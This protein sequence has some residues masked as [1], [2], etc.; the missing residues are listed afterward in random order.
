MVADLFTAFDPELK[1][2]PVKGKYIDVSDPMV[3]K[4]KSCNEALVCTEV[5]E[6]KALIVV[7][8]RQHMVTVKGVE[9]SFFGMVD[10]ESI[11]LGDGDLMLHFGDNEY[12][13]LGVNLLTSLGLTIDFTDTLD[14]YAP[15]KGENISLVNPMNDFT[16]GELLSPRSA[17][18]V[19]QAKYD[20]QYVLTSIDFA[21]HLFDKDSMVTGLEMSLDPSADVD[22]VKKR[23]LEETGGKFK[24]LDRYEQQSDI[25]KIM[26]VEKLVSY[27]FLTFII[28]IACCRK[29]LHCRGGKMEIALARGKKL[30]DKR[31]DIKTLHNLGASNRDISRIFLFEGWLISVVGAVIGILIG[32]GLC[33]LQQEYGF[34]KFGDSSGNYIIDV[35]PVSVKITDIILVFVTVAIIGFLAVWYPVKHFSNKQIRNS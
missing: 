2:L 9:D 7:N 29:T 32:V 12:G 24:I 15:K 16:R 18:M 30:H 33:L 25:F 35:Y 27:I 21:R 5:V 31:E 4:V 17:F 14:V 20:N 8:D 13:I 34:L 11:K 3:K 28:L 1:V 10:F 23:L 6:D 19:L 22:K 26:E